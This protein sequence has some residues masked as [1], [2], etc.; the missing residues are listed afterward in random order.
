MVLSLAAYVYASVTTETHR[1]DEG[2]AFVLFLADA[3]TAAAIVPSAPF[4]G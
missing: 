3:F 1:F 4:A 2:F